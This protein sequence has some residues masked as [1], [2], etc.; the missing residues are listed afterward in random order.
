MKCARFLSVLLALLFVWSTAEVHAADK[1][2]IIFILV[3]DLG[4]GDLGC[5][6]QNQRK[7]DNLPAISTPNIDSMAE[8]GVRL[9]RHYSGAPVC[10]PSRASLFSG[11]HQGNARVV[12]DNTF[13]MPLENS[14]TL[15]TML[16]QA[17]YNT[18]LI[19]KWG[20]GG[21][22]ESAGGPEES[23]AY[24]TKR[25]FDYFFGYLDHIA[26]H[27][28]YPKEDPAHGPRNLTAIWDQDKIITDQCDKTY[29]TDLLTARAK[30]WIVDTHKS[31]PNQPFFLALTLIAPHSALKVPT[32]PY[33]EGKGLKGGLQWLGK[34][35]ELINTAHGQI[36]NYIQPEYQKH[37]D[38]P[39]SAKRHATMV[40]RIDDAVGDILQLLKDLNIDK[41]TF[42]VFTSDNGPHNEG[43]F[44]RFVQ[45][46]QFFR[47]YGPFDG[48][49]RD[50]WEGGLRVPAIVSWPSQATQHQSLLQ[51][52]Q[53][54][55][56]M[57][58]FADLAQIPVPARC[59]GV[60]LLPSLTGHPERQEDGVV[61]FEYNFDGKTPDYK[62]FA[63][64]HRNAQRGQMQVIYVDGYKGI[65]TDIKNH[66]DPFQIFDTATDN[67]EKNDLANSLPNADLIQQKMKDKSLQI[68]RVYDYYN[69]VRGN[70]AQ[71]PYDNEL[72]PSV[73]VDN[74][75]QGLVFSL[76]STKAQPWVTRTQPNAKKITTNGL[77][78]PKQLRQKTSGFTGTW[79][80][81]INIPKDG[82]YTFYVTT[83]S[84]RGSKALI[85]L[86]GT[87]GLVLVDADFDYTPGTTVNSSSAIGTSECVPEQTGKTPIHLQAGLHPITIG[88]VHGDGSHA[89]SLKFEWEGPGIQRQTVPTA[90]FHCL[91]L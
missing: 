74:T 71:R 86:H 21:G 67:Q 81:W 62:D 55:D 51:P 78:L 6:Y 8:G 9:M 46:P 40:S 4:W 85:R 68:R 72:V 11:V 3:D 32:S 54:Q 53:F 25:G 13:D 15:A 59:D 91:P 29:S 24:P 30:Q 2:N 34:P 89:P 48:I 27:R 90:Q 23:S 52:S 14:H 33:P 80:G 49:K 35:G 31:Q 22:R 76:D 87:S 50:S 10:A 12:R 64:G 77:V 42:V 5:F 63:E 61:Y 7:T 18:A 56:W 70:R 39:E 19:G 26:G 1:P 75:Q 16:K 57:A 28:H 41:N 69:T 66:N 84:N 37:S 38:W 20:I 82:D 73:Q 58:T 36:D 47:S 45:D 43:S 44:Y 88:Y 65:R 60:S 17:G 83:D 79:T